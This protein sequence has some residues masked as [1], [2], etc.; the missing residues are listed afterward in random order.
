MR[1]KIIIDCLD[2]DVYGVLAESVEVIKNELETT[3]NN[4]LISVDECPDYFDFRGTQYLFDDF[5]DFDNHNNL[6]YKPPII[7]EIN[8]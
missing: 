1:V 8:D 4:L 6:V 3:I 2:G 7:L 5:I